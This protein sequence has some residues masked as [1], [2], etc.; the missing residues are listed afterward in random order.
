MNT[1]A[2]PLIFAFFAA[3]ALG[4]GILL[5]SISHK[6][7][8]RVPVRVLRCFYACGFICASVGLLL[9]GDNLLKQ[10]Y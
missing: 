4:S 10:I 3:L 6:L 9:L 8:R 7:S 5:H 2:D 1:V